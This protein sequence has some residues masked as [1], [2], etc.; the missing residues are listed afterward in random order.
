MIIMK[1]F[2]KRIGALI[3]SAAMLSGMASV[4]S[5]AMITTIVSA[6]GSKAITSDTLPKTLAIPVKETDANGN[7][8]KD[9]EGNDVIKNKADVTY[10]ARVLDLA[11]SN[12]KSVQLHFT[13]DQPV[14][15]FAYFAGISL[16]AEPW[17]QSITETGVKCAPYSEDFYLTIDVSSIKNI[18]YDDTY[19]EK[20]FEFQ[21]CYCQ[22]T[23]GQPIEITLV[24][25]VANGTKDTSQGT[26]PATGH[27]NT[28]GA[29]FETGNNPS[30]NY[31]FK[32]NGNGTATI[33]ATLSKKI[34]DVASFYKEKRGWNVN[35]ITLTP[36]PEGEDYSEEGYAQV[37]S[38][39]GVIN[40]SEQEIREAGNPLNSHKFSYGD[41]GI[42]KNQSDTAEITIESLSVV[43]RAPKGTNVTRVM[44][45]GG[46]N[47][48]GHS[49]ADTEWTKN[50][51]GLK[52]DKNAGYWYNDIGTEAYEDTMNAIADFNAANPDKAVDFGVT[53]GGGKDLSDQSFGDYVNVTWDVPA[54]VVPYTT[55]MDSDTISFQLWYGEIEAEDYTPLDSLVMESAALTYTQSITFP[56]KNNTTKTYTGTKLDSNGTE[57]LFSDFDIDYDV[58]CDVYGMLFTIQTASPVDTMVL[59]AGTSV[60]ENC[61]TS[62]SDYWYQADAFAGTTTSEARPFTLVNADESKNEYTFMWVMPGNVAKGLVKGTDGNYGGT[63]TNYISTEQPTDNFKLAVYYAGLEG[64]EVTNVS[65][66]DVTLYYTTDDRDNAAKKD[67]FEDDLF[68]TPGKLVLEVGEEA[69]LKSSVADSIFTTGDIDI[70]TVD[71][72]GNV[73]AIGE[74]ETTITVKSPQGQTAEVS[75]VVKGATTTATTVTT[76]TTT[77]TTT[78]AT[79]TTEPFDPT[80]N[81]IYG[82]TNLDGLVSLIDLV[83]LNKYLA[84]IITFNAQQMENADCVY[85]HIINNSDSY[86]LLKYMVEAADKL[87]PGAV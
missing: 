38:N 26:A 3:V 17:Y 57:F 80:L 59:G 84:T 68:V 13:A 21:N 19:G 42:W 30:G 67:M 77:T 78:K 48:V 32:D 63:G 36:S 6:A 73:K 5:G 55:S 2:G 29:G 11:K 61:G 81:A 43:L 39:G 60:R 35:D 33:T 34:D 85:D 24:D 83:Y 4:S 76:T 51:A 37:G 75:V 44:Y 54:E 7:V 72:D 9:K 23:K 86:L 65:V 14:A 1:K 41:F 28:G 64:K 31:T 46:L 47:V 58:T 71:K 87:G 27:E 50:Q 82:D 8:V 22:S 66:K 74:G 70:V 52:A 56:Y 69:T 15:Q 45:G 49:P 25:V 16:D 20:K 79:T 10:T 62:T 18:G 53:V 40:V 12:L